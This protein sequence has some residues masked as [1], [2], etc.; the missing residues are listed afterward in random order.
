MNGMIGPSRSASVRLIMRA[1]SVEPVKTTPASSGCAVSVPPTT[2]PEPGASWTTSLGMPAWCISSTASAPISG[3]C[4]A[5]LAMTALPAA[6]GADDQAGEDRQ[7]EI[8][9]RNA[10]EHA[11]AVQAQLVLLAGRAGQRQRP[12]EL[13]PRLG[14][15]EAQEIDRLAHFEH[16]VDQGL[17]GFANAQREELLAM[18]LVEVGGAVEQPRPRLPAERI[19]ILLR[20]V[21]GADHP[22]D[23][24]GASLRTPSRPSIRRSCGDSDRPAL[25]FSKRRLGGPAAAFERLQPLEQ[26][27]AHQRIGQVDTG[28]VAALGAE[29]VARQ[30]DLRIALGLER[31][32]LGDRIADQ[33]VDRDLLVGDAVDEAELAPFS[34]RRRTR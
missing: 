25:A 12:G 29:H 19:P 32:E 27:L 13:A 31:V 7:R 14:G 16:R 5:G 2:L 18:L 34:S 28:A 26:R 3:V 17:P 1:V 6:S 9:R 22:V 23:L 20:G 33:L 15:V 30:D 8:P 10:G 11:A 24:G 4:P 21:A